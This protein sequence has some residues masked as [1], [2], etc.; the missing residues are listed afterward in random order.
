MAVAAGG[1][2]YEV[3]SERLGP[4]ILRLKELNLIEWKLAEVEQP[5]PRSEH[6]TR[7]VKLTDKGREVADAI[8]KLAALLREAESF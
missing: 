2:R 3:N 8:L 7:I 6:P 1:Y 4:I 5:A